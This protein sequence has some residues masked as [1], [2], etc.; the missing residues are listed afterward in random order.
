MGFFTWRRTHSDINYLDLTP[1]RQLD[2][3]IYEENLVKIKIP[4]FKSPFMKHF[5]PK[6]KSQYLKVK[7]DKLGSEVWMAMDGKNKVAEIID[8][9]SEKFGEQIQPAEERITKFLTNL[10][11]NKFI[12]FN[13]INKEKNG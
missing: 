1:S 3:E 6:N 12:T 7:L 10:Y 8:Q 9:L 11:Q 2:F 5:I 4:R 13:E